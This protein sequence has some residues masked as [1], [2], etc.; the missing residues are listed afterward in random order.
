[1]AQWLEG[2]GHAQDAGDQG[3]VAWRREPGCVG[4]NLAVWLWV[5][6]RPL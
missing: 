5:G 6:R 4:L 3:S 2:Q 1:M